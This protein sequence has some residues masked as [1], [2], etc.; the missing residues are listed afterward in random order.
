LVAHGH[1]L[2]PALHVAASQS[3]VTIPFVEYLIRHQYSKQNF[4]H[5]I[6]LPQDGQMAL[7]E[8]NGL[9]F[10]LDESKIERRSGWQ[11]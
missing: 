10:E 5:T 3:P 1:S 6:Y 7:P 8:G 2:L 11:G 4:H 9:G